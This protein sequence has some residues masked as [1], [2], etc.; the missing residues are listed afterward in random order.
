MSEHIDSIVKAA[1]ERAAVYNVNNFLFIRY[2]QTKCVRACEF[3]L[4]LNEMHKHTSGPELA[5][6]VS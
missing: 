6:T 2:I 3:V 5:V 4:L 1:A